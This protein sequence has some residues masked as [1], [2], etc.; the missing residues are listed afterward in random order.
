MTTKPIVD[1]AGL[2]KEQLDLIEQ[3]EADYNAVDQ[4]LRKAL[5]SDKP[6]TFTHLVSEYS[7]NHVGWRDADLL[8]TIAD[9][10]NVIVHTKTA[11]YRYLAVPTPAITQNLRA[12]RDRLMNP[13]RAI[14]TFQRKV[15]TV[16]VDD[17]LAHVLKIIKERDYSQFPVYEAER[18]RGLLTEN[19]ITRWLAQHVATKLSLVELDDAPVNEVLQNEERRRNYHFAARDMRVDDVRGLFQLQEDLEAVLITASG[20]ESEGLLG[21]ATRW[22]MIHLP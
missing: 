6:V 4:F 2:P 5:G 16:S 22:D 11:P 1:E 18:F 19:G 21:I 7:H 3:F 9:L 12:C 8:K 20:K 15:D 10:R 17:K 13:A 14:P